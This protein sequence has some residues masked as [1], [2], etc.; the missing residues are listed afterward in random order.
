MPRTG[1]L[2]STLVTSV[3]EGLNILE[4]VKAERIVAQISVEYPADGGF[5]RSF[6]HW[7]SLR[8]DSQIGGMRRFSYAEFRPAGFRGGPKAGE[9]VSPGRFFRRLAATS[10]QTNQER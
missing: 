7:F 5:P 6:L 9:P 4:I 2:R 1:W 8:A 3:V 10:C